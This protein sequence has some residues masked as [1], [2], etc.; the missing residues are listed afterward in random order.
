MKILK[1]I[2]Y[3]Y[4]AEEA[5]GPIPVAYNFAKRFIERGHEVTIWTSNLMTANSR[6]SNKTFTDQ[7]EGIEVTYLNSPLRYRWAAITPSLFSLCRNRLKDFDIIHFYAYRGFM[8]LVVSWYAKKYDVPYVLQALGTVPIL[9]RSRIK[10]YVYDHVFGYRILENAQRLIAKSPL[11]KKQYLEVHVPERKTALV[12]NGIDISELPEGL[13]RGGFKKKFNIPENDKV[14]LFLARIHK[15]KGLDILIKAF[16]KIKIENVK[17]VI[18]GPDDG[19]LKETLKLVREMSINDKVIITG[20]LYGRD[21]FQA[22]LDADIYVLP[23]IQENYPKS[24][25]EAVL[26]KVPVIITEDCGIAH[27]IRDRVGLAIPYDVDAL[28][29][30][31]EKLLTDSNLRKSFKKNSGVLL[32][33]HFSWETHVDK[34]E[35]LYLEV[36]NGRSKAR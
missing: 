18:T 26:C 3:F 13:K 22:Y 15:R 10:K 17:L 34:L 14:I 8:P 21:K 20:P 6:M 5:G 23:A 24:V 33:E 11:E 30:A 29:F 7:R 4:P 2:D 35:K 16:S 12:P 32:Q 25:L 1:L 27:L 28:L 31:L 9:V 19:F 36:L